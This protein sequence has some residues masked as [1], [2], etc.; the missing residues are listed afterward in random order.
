MSVNIALSGLGAAQKD[1]NTTSNNIANA[2]TY[3]FKESRAEFGDVYSNSIFSNAKTS[4]GGGVQT[5]TVAQQF[6]EG[7]SLY[8]NNPLDLRIS[9]AGFFAV[10]D[11]KAEPANNSLTRNGA[12][13]LNNQ[14]ELVNSEGKFLLGYEVNSDTNTVSSYEPKSMQIDDVF[15]KPTPSKNMD[16]SLNLP[17]KETM[18]KNHPF[19][20]DDKDSYSRSTS[21]T[22]YDS[23]G[24]PY[25]MNTYYVAKYNPANPATANTWEVY[26]T[27]TNPSGKEL[28]LDVD[29]TKLDP[30]FVANGAAA[31]KGYIMKFDTSGQLQ[32]GSPS[33]IDMVNFKKAGIDVGGADDSQALT[34]NYKEPTQYAS[35]FEVRQFKDVDGATTGYL[36]KVDIDPD[37]NVLA[38]YSN[39]KDRIVGRVAMARVSNEQGLSQLGGTLWNVTQESGDAVWGDASQGSFGAIKSGTLEQSNIDMTQEL[40]DLI[41][42]QR[43]FQASSRALEVNNQLQQN[44][45]QIR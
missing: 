25:K 28:P 14:N 31:H 26:H 30:T 9:G 17:N 19:N 41:T 13:H 27:V 12:F 11:N 22:I 20:F 36:S 10:A 5:S 16:I 4:T 45:L 15:G 7:S 21:S 43:N 18:P 33:V 39:G 37:G 42:A 24:K 6:H 40:V 2:N 38:S 34:M 23:L 8:T 32:A 29:T 1:L 3:G 35:P 44:I